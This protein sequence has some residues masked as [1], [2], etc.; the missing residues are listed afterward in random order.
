M[1]YKIVMQIHNY[2]SLILVVTWHERKNNDIS[3]ANMH[4][5]LNYCSGAGI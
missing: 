1:L 5:R 4:G 2:F 3:L